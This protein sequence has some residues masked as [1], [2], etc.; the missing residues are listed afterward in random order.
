MHY[1]AG[2]KQRPSRRL[3]TM[4]GNCSLWCTV[5]IASAPC[6]MLFTNCPASSRLITKIM[7]AGE[8]LEGWRKQRIPAEV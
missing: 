6:G 8:V 7:I 5:D 3:G 4:Q 2:S 1:F